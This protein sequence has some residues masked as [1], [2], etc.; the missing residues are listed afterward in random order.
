MKIAL[1]RRL[2]AF[3]PDL[4]DARLRGKVEAARFIDGKLYEV[5]R[6]T[7]PLRREPRHDAALDTEALYGER[8]RVFEIDEE[9]WAWGQL[10]ADGYAGYLPA[11]ALA[12][13]GTPATHKVTALRTHGFPGPDIKLPPFVALPL[14]GRIAVARDDGRFAI[15]AAG[16]YVPLR[17]IAPL[18]SREQD[19]VA[20]A[21]RFLGAP[22]LWGGKTTQGIDC[23]GLVQVALNAAGIPCQRDS[24]MQERAFSVNVSLDAL[25][26]GDMIFWEGHVAIARDAETI[27][28]ANAFHMA[29]AIEPVAGAVARIK[30]AGNDVS[31]VRR[32]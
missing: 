13:A 10:E 27:V 28:H 6:E 19:Y 3:R 12:W 16:L 18:D 25:R 20:L 15:T 14:G 8:V 21:E 32:L 7:A 24:D 23:S 22:Y 1:D 11:A 5:V 9:G 2:N 31:S 30:A 29:V 4:A 17:H 26:R